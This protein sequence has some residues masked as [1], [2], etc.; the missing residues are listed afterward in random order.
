MPEPGSIRVDAD[1]AGTFL[2]ITH[3]QACPEIGPAC[4]AGPQQP[5]LHH[6]SLTLANLDLGMEA[7]ILPGL[8]LL[9]TVPM[10]TMRATVHYTTLDGAPYDPPDAGIHHRN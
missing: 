6:Q 8:S 5:Y 7:G 10:K 3:V 4:N 9:A 2:S 1:G